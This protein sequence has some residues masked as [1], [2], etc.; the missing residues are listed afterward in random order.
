MKPTTEAQWHTKKIIAS[1]LESQLEI[2][3]NKEKLVCSILQKNVGLKKINL[4][5]NGFSK[6]GATMLG[7]AL[8][9]NR[10]LLELDISNNRLGL[11]AIPLLLK[12]LQENDGLETL[13]VS[14]TSL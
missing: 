10:T 13:H 3:L 1:N 7:Q 12:G 8:T 4:G 6:V 2:M 9:E 11:T 14:C 5:W